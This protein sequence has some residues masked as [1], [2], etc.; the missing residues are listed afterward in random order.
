MAGSK[1]WFPYTT[2]TENGATVFGLEADESNTEGVMGAEPELPNPAPIFTLPKNVKP[3]NVVLKNSDGATRICYVL[4]E[5]RFG[6][7]N[8]NQ[9]DLITGFTVVRKNAEKITRTV[10]NIDTGQTDGDVEGDA[11]GP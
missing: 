10:V 2:N 8:T 3:R 1:R 9:S 7:I 4:T 6:A 5:T 11:P